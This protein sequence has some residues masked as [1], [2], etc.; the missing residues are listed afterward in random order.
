MPAPHIIRLHGPWKCS[1][2]TDTS[3]DE[4][5]LDCHHADGLQRFLAGRS[6]QFTATRRFH[7]AAGIGP[8]ISVHLLLRCQQAPFSIE[9]NG[10]PFPTGDPMKF[11][12]GSLFQPES[13]LTLRFEISDPIT[14][15]GLL[16]LFEAQLQ[17][18]EPS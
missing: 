5:K 10:Q 16:D 15:A 1:L 17:F 11:D 9:M 2:K 13:E 18:S 12:I 7:R 6:G 4:A 14:H 3:V 8:E